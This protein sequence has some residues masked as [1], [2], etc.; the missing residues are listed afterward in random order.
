MMVDRIRFNPIE[1]ATNVLKFWIA[2]FA[3][4]FCGIPTI[5]WASPAE[6]E[7]YMSEGEPYSEAAD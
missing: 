6:W 2:K 5:F 4:R 3:I 7:E 1:R